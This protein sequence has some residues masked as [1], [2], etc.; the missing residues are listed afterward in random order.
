MKRN[1]K[2][3]TFFH[4]VNTY[5]L[6]VALG[7]F[8][9]YLFFARVY[10]VAPN[11]LVAVG[12]SLGVWIVYT[13]D[14]IIDGLRLKKKALSD[15]HLV[16]YMQRGKLILICLGVSIILL[17]LSVYIP[18]SYY[19][20]TLALAGL[21]GIHFLINFFVPRSIKSKLFLKEVFISFVVTVGF[22]FTPLVEIDYVNYPDSL[23]QYFVVFFTLNLTN[24]LTFSFYDS[25]KDK[26][27]GVL[28]MASIHGARMTR[29]LGLIA[30]GVSMAILMWMI[31]EHQTALLPGLT[32]G[33]MQAVLTMVLVQTESFQQND[34]YRFWGDF[35]YVIPLFVLPFL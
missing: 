18:S 26:Q 28:S 24:L 11:F 35:I 5:S 25:E 22:C 23:V 7:S 16:H 2:Q 3:N 21:T 20:Y 27:N 13:V 10:E 19:G 34:R 15:R 33:A 8:S 14:H 12:L 4:F 1:I 31:I 32:I 9:S 6:L 29:V 17:F 30:I